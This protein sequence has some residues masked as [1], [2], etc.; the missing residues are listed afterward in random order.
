MTRNFSLLV[1]PA[2]YCCNLRCR[3]CFYLR[4]CG[5]F[6]SGA[7]RMDE[8]VLSTMI[9]KF[10][11]IGMPVSSFGWQGGEP[12]LMGLDF[13][14]RALELQRQFAKPGQ[15]VANALQTNGTLLDDQWGAFLNANK[16]LV[17][18]S[19]D[20]P[21]GI[22][23]MSRVWA[24]G[25]GSHADVMRGMD[26][27]KRHGVEFNVL[28]LVSSANQD[29]PLEIY[30]YLKSLGVMYHQ[31][32]ECVEFDE[33]RKLSPFSVDPLKW[34]QLL[35]AVFDEWI[36]ADTRTVS[37]RLF[38]SVLVKL[39][40]KVANVCAL[41]TDCRQY[42]VVE[43]NGDIF[44][45]DFHVNPEWRLGNIL[46]EDFGPLLDSPLYRSFGTRKRELSAKC[47]ACEFLDICAGCCPKNRPGA[48]PATTSALC[49][50]WKLFY[51]H[52]LERFKALAADI[53]KERKAATHQRTAGAPPPNRNAP[54]PCGIGRKY[55][56]CCGA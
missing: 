5:L 42:F 10:M 29:R 11:A 16:F 15:R 41:G 13:Y 50:G 52:S 22:H 55:K 26:V 38:D 46:A 25:R 30:N 7:L 35:C 14:R 51:G 24:D 20:G 28:T 44:P 47:K 4:K 53:A 40:D 6:G 37:V 31:Y 56:K 23:D 8:L 48:N 33:D 21:E 43:H 36:K 19:V 49:E 27:L 18:I 54:C 12:T 34:G 3:Y 17:G 39:L 1:K 32:I 45:C 9:R 2:S